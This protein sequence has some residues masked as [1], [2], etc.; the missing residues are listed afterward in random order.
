MKISLFLSPGA[1]TGLFAST[2][3]TIDG[4]SSAGRQVGRFGPVPLGDFGIRFCI[5][6][7]FIAGRAR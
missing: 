5:Q 7:Q 6:R 3:R 2:H 1:N 4:Q